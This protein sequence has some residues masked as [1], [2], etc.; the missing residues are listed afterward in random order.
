MVKHKK[1][2]RRK[3]VYR[4]GL[5]F[6]LDFMGSPLYLG[7]HVESIGLAKIALSGIRCQPPNGS[8]VRGFSF[9]FG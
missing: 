7:S 5:C 9:G 6:S 1:S 4:K 8:S 2:P 3:W